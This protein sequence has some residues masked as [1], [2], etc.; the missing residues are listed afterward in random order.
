MQGPA[1]I[2]S[3]S[4]IQEFR[5]ALVMYVADSKQGVATLETEIRRAFDWIAVDRAQHWRQ[6]IRRATDAVARARD[7]LHNART[8]KS[9]G[10]YTPS[11]VDE[12]KAVQRA[13]ERL[14]M[15][16]GKAE[17]VRKWTRSLQHEL[18][19]FAGRMSQF[20]AVLEIDLPKAMAMLDRVLSALDRYVS[21]TAPRPMAEPGQVRTDGAGS[22]AMPL[23]ERADGD[24]ATKR[25]EPEQPA[26]VERATGSS[27]NEDQ[28]APRLG[29]NT[30]AGATI[31]SDVDAAAAATA[32]G[33]EARS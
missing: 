13:E 10:D 30:T 3:I 31:E 29:G 21:T 22:M 20:A 26:G 5:N 18:N 17:V 8:F 9:V 28:S 15:A 6:E 4:A 11:C 25:N 33:E 24:V 23:E 2:S 32:A 12:R 7:D 1:Y 14:K 19:E 27:A 16:E